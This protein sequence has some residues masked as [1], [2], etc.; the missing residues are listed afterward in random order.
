MNCPDGGT[1]HHSC[2]ERCWRV[3]NAGPL[4]AAGYPGD[5]WPEGVRREHSLDPMALS[6]VLA[7]VGEMADTSDPRVRAITPHGSYAFDVIGLTV[8]SGVVHLRLLE[9]TTACPECQAGKCGNCDGTS[10]DARADEPTTCPCS[11]L[12]HPRRTA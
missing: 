12:D 5:Q 1:C 2:V 10:W 7:T 3:R 4:S 11:L 9:Q 8:E 6:D